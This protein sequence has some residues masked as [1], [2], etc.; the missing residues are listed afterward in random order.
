MTLLNTCYASP[1]LLCALQ[2]PEL[3][4]SL[5]N[6]NC[7]GCTTLR[8]L[9]ELQHTC[10]TVL[11]CSGCTQLTELPDMP[12]SLSELW[13]DQVPQIT[14][15]PRLP[16]SS[17]E[18][19]QLANTGINVLPDALPRL[20]TL[21]CRATPI[22]QLPDLPNCER[23]FLG[24]CAQLQQLPEQV[25][26]GLISL[27]CCEHSTLQQ[28]PVPLPPKLEHLW[29]S[30]CTALEVLPELPATLVDLDCQGCSSLRQLPDL[31]KCENLQD[32][33]LGGCGALTHFRLGR[34]LVQL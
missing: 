5:S 3:P 7:A 21:G 34:C 24:Y 11:D 32:M 14:S 1:A 26:V 6:L 18:V 2:L 15:L 8:K 4:A 30:S 23:L 16:Y 20:R 9:P 31:S 27:E 10:I 19:L 17:L 33:Q 28:L 13:A 25:P 29:V 12:D 22:Q